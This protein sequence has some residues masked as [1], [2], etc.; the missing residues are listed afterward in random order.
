MNT[1]HYNSQ[2]YTEIV[3][4]T[5]IIM[6]I[7]GAP[8]QIHPRCLQKSTKDG[9]GGGGVDI[10]SSVHIYTATL[11]ITLNKYSMSFTTSNPHTAYI[12]SNLGQRQG[13]GKGGTI[14]S[15]SEFTP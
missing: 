8:F 15:Q 6:G 5:I 7:S 1:S 11:S 9:I 10:L 4:V 3:I 2:S 12:T 13:V 14:H